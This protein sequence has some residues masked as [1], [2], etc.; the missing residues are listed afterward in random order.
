MT[1]DEQIDDLVSRALEAGATTRSGIQGYVLWRH[2]KRLGL[3][4]YTVIKAVADAL[5]RRAVRAERDS[6]LRQ[7]NTG[8]A[9]R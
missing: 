6:K 5:C 8:E 7:G 4:P 1:T 3:D 2:E 9:L